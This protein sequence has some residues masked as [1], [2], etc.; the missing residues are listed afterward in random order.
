MAGRKVSPQEEQLLSHAMREVRP[1]GPRAKA[2]K[3]RQKKAA[4]PRLQAAANQPIS[5]SAKPSPVAAIDRRTEQKLRRGRTPIEGVLDLHGLTQAEAHRRLAQFIAQAAHSGH[6]AV[7]I[8]TGKGG[9]E[10]GHM[11]GEGRGVLKRQ[12]PLW[13]E[14][15]A[16][17]ALVAGIKPAGPRHG[18]GGALYV[19]LKRPKNVDAAR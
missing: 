1:L 8:I 15:P 5:A 6:K 16:L 14:E 11:P 3:P 7:L 18:G 12:V 9:P 17:R 4:A 13:L 19:L 10:P 2:H